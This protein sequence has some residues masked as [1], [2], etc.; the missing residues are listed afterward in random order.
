MPTSKPE[1]SVLKAFY[2][3]GGTNATVDQI[4]QFVKENFLEAGTEVKMLRDVTVQ[5]VEWID[6]IQDQVY[7]GW[8]DHLNNAWR[9]LTFVFDNSVLCKG[10]VSSTL[11]VKRP[12]VVPGG[13]FREFYYWD[14][15]FVIKGLLLS[16]QIGL[17]RDMIEN[18]FDFIDLYGFMPNGA[19][20]YYLN[21]SQPPFLSLMVKIYY[22][23]TRD[24]DF[25]IHALPYLDKEYHFWMSNSTIQIKDPKNPKKTYILNH[26]TT[27]NKSPRPESYVEDYNAVNQS[28]STSIKDRMY[29]D[30]AAGAETGW[31]Y[32]SRWTINKVASPHQMASYEMLRTINTQNII[33]ID[34]N[35]LLWS[36]EHNLSKWHKLFTSNK[37]KSIYYAQQARNRLKAIDRLMWNDKDCSF[38]DFNL[39]S[40]A[41][42]AEYT[43]ANLYPFWLDAIPEH[44]L[45]NKTKLSHTMDETERSLRKYPGILTTSYHNTTMQWD[46]PNGWPPL[47]FIAIQ[48]FQNIN[49]ILNSQL[50]T[51]EAYKT[52]CNTSFDH[53]EQALADRYAASAYCGWHK[54]GGSPFE[55]TMDDGHMFEKFDVNSIGNIGGQGEY[56]PQ[57]GFGWTNGVAMWILDTFRNLKAP[58]DCMQMI[59]IDI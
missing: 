20:I 56:I 46:W 8:M 1:D 24:K 42:N 10:C 11:P 30:I 25:M 34:L 49:R 13:R 3:L 39:T 28:Y 52:G 45:S 4:K 16:E 53:L 23:K 14:S 58:R 26:Y 31:D 41:Q 9:N 15:F 36:M 38:Y 48:S 33:P 18:F 43:P 44:L 19:R 29:A 22:E 32:S 50:N 59:T 35:S 17:A 37:K 2:A 27:Q 57:I 6:G 5:K 54:T 40:R 21:R 12:F 55:K 51:S 47:T 7:Q